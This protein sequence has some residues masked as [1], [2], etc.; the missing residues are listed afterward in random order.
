M[1]AMTFFPFLLRPL[2]LGSA[3]LPAARNDR[4]ADVDLIFFVVPSPSSRKPEMMRVN[5]F[6]FSFFSCFFF[7]LILITA[8]HSEITS[9]KHAL[10]LRRSHFWRT[11]SSAKIEPDLTEISKYFNTIFT[12]L[13]EVGPYM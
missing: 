13:R 1:N 3:N 11:E 10:L 9:T 8:L 4:R 5:F 2:K 12:T 6:S 7:L